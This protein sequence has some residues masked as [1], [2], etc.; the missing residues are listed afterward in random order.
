MT[1]DQA[2]RKIIAAGLEEKWIQEMAHQFGLK[3]PDAHTIH[4]ELKPRAVEIAIE[5]LLQER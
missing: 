3:G 2:R 1:Y 4:E 5:I